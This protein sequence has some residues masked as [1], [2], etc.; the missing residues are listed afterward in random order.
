M[1]VALAF[2]MAKERKLYTM[3]AQLR[4][5]G[6]LCCYWQLSMATV[7]DTVTTGSAAIAVDFG[8]M[9]AHVQIGV[10]PGGLA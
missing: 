2:N 7:I 8:A 4:H 1:P 10:V 3:F 9:I 6:S 5:E